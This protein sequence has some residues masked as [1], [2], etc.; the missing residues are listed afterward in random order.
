MQPWREILVAVAGLT[1]QVITET[2]Y[3]LTQVRD[4]PV[5]IAEI[6]I[7]T[8]RPGRERI[9]TDLLTPDHGRF[10]T[11]CAEYG[12]DPSTIAF[13]DAHIQVL[14]DVVGVPLEDIRTA[15]DSAAVADQILAC[16]RRLT[17]DPTTRLHCS[18]AG[19]RKTLSVLLGFAL[20]LY[21]RV[22]D[23]LLHVLIRE[24]LEGHTA[25]FYPPKRP[26]LIQTRNG[27]MV[28]AHR[29][30]VEVAEIPYVRLRE[31]LATDMSQMT[32]GFAPTIDRLQRTLDALPDL[33][34]LVIEPAARKVGIGTIQIPLEPM[35]IVLYTQL[36]LAKMR[37]EGRGDGFLSVKELN[38]KRDAMLRRYQQ[39]YGPYS[40]HVENL[41]QAWEKRIPP[42]R[43]RSRFS[44][45]SRK[46][47][48][49]VPRSIDAESYVVTSDRRYG[50]T[51]YGLRL[52]PER[53]DVRE[54]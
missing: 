21:G 46:I 51:C 26:T 52:S 37:R 19:G 44:K 8:T 29:V 49:A 50:A 7:L 17:D 13:D 22:Q 27:Q 14:T 48:Q 38:G 45:I 40:G 23:S 24:E 25:F 5:G 15:A 16:I 1:P 42:A 11:F 53:I 33:P 6:H 35:E 36:A 18:L 2:L 20:Q 43:L 10:Y 3:Y 28:E 47:R 32:P 12:L 4:P 31:K 54:T 34:P 30:Q 39:L 9:R 41:R